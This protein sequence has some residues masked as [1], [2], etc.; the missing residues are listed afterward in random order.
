MSKRSAKRKP[1][2]RVEPDVKLGLTAEQ[3]EERRQNGYANVVILPMVRE[4]GRGDAFREG[5]KYLA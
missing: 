5:K 1:I 4:P 3:V 2:T